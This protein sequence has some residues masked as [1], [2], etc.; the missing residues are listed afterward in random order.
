MNLEADSSFALSEAAIMKIMEA[1][2]NGPD[3]KDSSK[4]HD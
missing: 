3:R 1:N 2:K 4:F